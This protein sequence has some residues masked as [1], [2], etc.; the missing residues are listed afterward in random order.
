MRKPTRSIISSTSST[1]S[2]ST[3]EDIIDHLK[4]QKFRGSTR[5]NYTSVWK[6]FNQF[7][8]QLDKK[9]KCWEDRITLF[10]GYLIHHKGAKSQTV[11]SYLSVIRA[12][13]K[14][15][16]IKLNEDLFLLNSLTKACKLQND[17][18]RVRLPIQKPLLAE[19]LKI[20]RGL[21]H[22]QQY[23]SILFQTLFATSYFGLFRVSELTK[24]E[25]AV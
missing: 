23:L 15:D 17:T 3:I 6:S 14:N 9:P 4:Y 16:G 5:K 22:D 8:I 2:T 13:L 20:V 19:I 7:Y 18:F 24:G 1:I 25:H 21:F 12:T 10:V 11:K